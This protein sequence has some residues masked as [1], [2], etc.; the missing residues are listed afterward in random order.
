[1][2]DEIYWFVLG[3]NKIVEKTRFVGRKM[4]E[5]LT[6]PIAHYFARKHVKKKQNQKEEKKI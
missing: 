4:G 2:I 1:M 3:E 6:A 5:A